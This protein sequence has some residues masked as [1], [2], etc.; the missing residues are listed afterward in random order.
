MHEETVAYTNRG[1][2]QGVLRFM[3]FSSDEKEWEVIYRLGR[4][5]GLGTGA[6]YS[7]EPP[8]KHFFC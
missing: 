8:N 4:L 6:R 1:S 7:N 3:V 2:L 5:V